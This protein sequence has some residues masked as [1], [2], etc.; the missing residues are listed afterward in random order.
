VHFLL[1]D[2]ILFT[3]PSKP[4]IEIHLLY[5]LHQAS[6]SLLDKPSTD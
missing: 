4:H 5:R 1:K 3:V 6:F 2:L